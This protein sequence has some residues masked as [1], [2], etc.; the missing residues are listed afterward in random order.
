[1]AICNNYPRQSENIHRRHHRT[2]KKKKKEVTNKNFLLDRCEMDITV[3][4]TIKLMSS[5][6]R[7]KNTTIQIT[8]QEC[9][10]SSKICKV[11]YKIL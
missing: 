5:V 2:L 11:Y 3:L 4:Q 6:Q 10:I 7:T 1:M 8:K 9:H